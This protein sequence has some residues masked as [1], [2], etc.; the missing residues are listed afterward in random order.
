MIVLLLNKV[1]K[2]NN[3]IRIA[4]ASERRKYLP[5]NNNFWGQ[6]HSNIMEIEKNH[7]TINY[8]ENFF[9]KGKNYSNIKSY[10]DLA[11]YWSFW[12]KKSS[13]RI[14]TECKKLSFFKNKDKRLFFSYLESIQDSKLST[15]ISSESEP[16][17]KWSLKFSLPSLFYSLLIPVYSRDEL[18]QLGNWFSLPC[19]KYIWI[20]NRDLSVLDLIKTIQNHTELFEIKSVANCFTVGKGKPIQKFDLYKQGKI[21]MQDVGATII[22]Q[23]VPKVS[24]TILDLCAS[25]GNKTIQIFSNYSADESI[26][27]IAGDLPGSR[28][29]LLVERVSFLL[30]SSMNQ[31]KNDS[32]S[33]EI[34]QKNNNLIL[35]PWNASSL[36]I[37]SQSVNLIFIDA[38]CTG[39]GTMGTK[40]DVRYT[41]TQD[42]LNQQISLQQK[43]LHE[44]HRV[45]SP[46]GYIFYA[47]C[48]LLKEENEDQIN[49]FLKDFS[50]YIV[51]PLYH[52]LNSSKLLI[53]GSI[54]LFPPFSKSEGFFAIL[55][56]KSHN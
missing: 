35:K 11:T 13:E 33:Y 45:L 53:N 7:I 54:R 25:P 10:L 28:F 44:A 1:Y 30:G 6:V 27:V 48:S 29:R 24:G 41:F 37:E 49:L 43:L 5:Q 9:L 56:Q 39:S 16:S 50:N 34:S 51:I 2:G 38:P 47:T 26:K 15:I 22:S 14:L 12:N 46:G 21:I 17:I 19:P 31:L 55:L 42:F 52:P 40:P 8:I 4:L 18:H 36:P 3:S 23:L 32:E 20:N